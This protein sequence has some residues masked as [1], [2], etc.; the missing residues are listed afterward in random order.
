MSAERP[1]ASAAGPADGAWQA[2][3]RRALDLAA[4]GRG[5]TSPN[6]MVGALIMRDGEVIAEG[7]HRRAGGPHAEIDALSR[8]ED[9]RGATM[10]VSLEPCCH[11]GRTGPCTQALIGAGIARVVVGAPDPNPRV[12]GRGVAELVRAGIEVVTGVL[13]DE[14]RALNRVFETWITE[15]RP[16]VTLKLAMSLDGRIAAR[17]GERSAV[18]GEASWRRVMA[19]RAASDAVMIGRGTAEV[20]RP[21]LTVRGDGARGE[22]GE[23]F[24]PPWRVLVDSRL[25]TSPDV[26]L[27]EEGAPGV[28][29]ATALGEDDA[30]VAA[31]RARGVRV[32]SAPDRHGRVDVTALVAA[33]GGLGLTSILCEG[34]GELAA[35]LLAADVIDELALFVAPKIFGAGGVAAVGRLEEARAGFSLASVE[36]VGDD[37]LMTW[38]RTR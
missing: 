34:G 13:A 26:P 5:G 20:D 4:R 18:T 35:S 31:L 9:A 24:L 25:A 6:P 36:R 17:V 8:C 22:I 37:L 14:A 30:R 29:A 33:L 38:R 2:P 7:W 32:I 12:A 27:F 3:M 1:G 23:D 19:M 10:V 28:I 11:F 21:R 16:Y 15:G